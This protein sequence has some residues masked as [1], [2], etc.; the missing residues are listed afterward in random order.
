VKFI[1]GV[2]KHCKV[3]AK[4]LQELMQH[5]ATRHKRGAEQ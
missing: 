3:K 5:V 4:S 2:S 1:C